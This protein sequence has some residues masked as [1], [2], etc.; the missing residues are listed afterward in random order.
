MI[1]PT[2]NET[3]KTRSGLKKMMKDQPDKRFA[4]LCLYAG[5]G[6]AK[7]SKQVLV[8][9]IYEKVTQ[10]YRL[11]GA[12]NDIRENARVYQNSWH[13]GLFACCR[14]N[15]DKKGYTGGLPGPIDVAKATHNER[16]KNAEEAKRLEEDKTKMTLQ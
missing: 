2:Y 12:E 5:H 3:F 10:F 9:N 1:D 14:E 8:L 16:L 6:G 7:E 13:M 11:L 15:F 4:V